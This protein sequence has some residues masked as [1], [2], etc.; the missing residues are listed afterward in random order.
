MSIMLFLHGDLHEEIYMQVPQ[1][2]DV[3]NSGTVCKL[4]KSLY[5]LMHA[6]RQWY[7]KLMD[8]LRSKGYENSKND[9]SLLLKKAGDLVVFLA[10]YVEDIL[11]TGTDMNEM[12]SL[13]EFL[14]ATL[15]IC[16]FFFF[17]HRGF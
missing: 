7:S 6:S 12:Q 4:K 2:L 10:I 3:K 1:G 8:A 9:Y 5:G 14:D 16:I 15:E 17:G 13:K 11:L